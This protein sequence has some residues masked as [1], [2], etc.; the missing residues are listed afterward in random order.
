MATQYRLSKGFLF[1]YGWE[2]EL[3]ELSPDLFHSVFWALLD[4]QKSKGKIALPRPN[5][6]Q[7]KTIVSFVRL[8]IDNRLNGAKRN[9]ATG[10]TTGDTMGDSTGDTTAPKLSQDDYKVSGVEREINENT[11]TPALTPADKA[12]LI[13]EGIP[14]HYL[15]DQT[16]IIRAGKYAQEH[17]VSILTTYR[18]FWQKDKEQ[19]QTAQ[20]SY[21]DG[22]DFLDA[23]LK[24]GFDG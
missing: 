19:E 13:S 9:T 5:D 18:A 4:Y 10:D 2:E 20:A 14:E 15:S 17:N 12:A 22:D 3:R 21:G 16:R 6:P 11:P 8:Q 24:A 1:D 23:A 7:A